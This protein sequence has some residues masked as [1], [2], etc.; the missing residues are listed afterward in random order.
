MAQIDVDR[1]RL[2]EFCGKWQ[3][4]ELG[5]FGSALRDDF[6][7]D[8]DV[9][10]L[11]TFNPVAS[12]GLFDLVEMEEELTALF[13]RKVDLVE[14]EAVERSE[15]YIRRRHILSSVETMYAA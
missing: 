9:D 4:V 6:G 3:I 13:G 2:A 1:Q 15:N 5:L 11:V 8:S 10:V 12:W 14:R 7:P